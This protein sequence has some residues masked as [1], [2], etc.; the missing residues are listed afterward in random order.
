MGISVISLFACCCAL[1]FSKRQNYKPLPMLP[2]FIESHSGK[3]FAI[4]YPTANDNATKNTIIHIPA[5]AEEMNV[6]RRMIAVQARK[7]VAQGHAVLILDLFG[8]GESDG[9][10]GDA[11]WEIWLQNIDSAISCLNQKGFKGI[12]LWGLQ[13]GSLLAMNFANRYPNRIQGL[14]SWQPVLNGDVF[15]T[16]FLRLR[17]AAAMMNNNAPSEKTSD[18]KQQLLNGKKIEVTGYWLNP[19]LI[20][21]L[22]TLRAADLDLHGIKNDVLDLPETPL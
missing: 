20:K 1:Q 17:V 11:T 21:P 19:D 14:I 8:T 7:F 16:Q 6:S 15:V 2:L 10:F 22:I 9:D 13:L 5:F 4:Y 18:L 12:T 3:L